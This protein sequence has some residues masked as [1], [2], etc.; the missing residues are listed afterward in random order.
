M[1]P[2]FGGV[3][4]LGAVQINGDDG[5]GS[6]SYP[7][8]L[9]LTYSMSGLT[10]SLLMDSNDG[11]T[12][13]NTNNDGTVEEDSNENSYGIAVEYAIDALVLDAYYDTRSAASGSGDP[14]ALDDYDGEYGRDQF[15][16]MATYN[17]GPNS[18]RA[19]YEMAETDAGDLESD[20]ITLQAIHNVSD[21]LYVYTELLQRNDELG[22]QDE[23]SNQANVGAV[24]YF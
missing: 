23:E 12:A 5:N 11:A 24:Y 6:K 21:N 7:Y 17:I 10:V 20:V 1:S 3:T 8:Q 9:G 14:T 13:Y 4:F 16:L 15:G 2:S 18:F 22:S 19:S